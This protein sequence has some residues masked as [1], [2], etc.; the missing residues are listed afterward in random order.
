MTKGG[1][2]SFQKWLMIGVIVL[3]IASVLAE[4]PLST[5]APDITDYDLMVEK[6]AKEY[7]DDLDSFEGLVALFAALSSILTTAS[8]SLIGYAFIR[9]G[10]EG[11]SHHVA[12]RITMILAA[13]ILLTS[14]V[15]RSFSLF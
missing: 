13:V 2:Y 10:H 12:L 3:I 8:L 9:E 15:G 7:T 1:M 6:E 14:I 5:S 11:D 4:F